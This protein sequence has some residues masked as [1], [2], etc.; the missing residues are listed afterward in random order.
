ME[1][2]LPEAAG[3]VRE[4]G[5]E[6]EVLFREASSSWERG[7]RTGQGTMAHKTKAIFLIQVENWVLVILVYF[8][9]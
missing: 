6:K 4:A 8:I 7:A 1:L 5:E 9:K 2:P 3:T